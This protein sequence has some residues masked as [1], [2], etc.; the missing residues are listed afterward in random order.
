VWRTQVILSPKPMRTD[1]NPWH[2]IIVVTGFG[3]APSHLNT[4]MG[5]PTQTPQG[6]PSIATAAAATSDSYLAL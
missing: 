3:Q 4:K 6:F 2:M 5:P 1:E